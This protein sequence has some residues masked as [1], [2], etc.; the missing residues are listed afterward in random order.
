MTFVSW[1]C[2]AGNGFVILGREKGKEKR[3]PV[4][5][6]VNSEKQNKGEWSVAERTSFMEYLCNVEARVNSNVVLESSME[7]PSRGIFFCP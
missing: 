7:C 2:P 5:W 3:I 4:T 6:E 1:H